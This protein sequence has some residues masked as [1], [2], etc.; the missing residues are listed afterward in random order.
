MGGGHTET[1]KYLD[2]TGV[3]YG[4][5]QVDGKIRVSSM[6]YLYDI[7]EGNVTGHSSWEKYAINDD[8]D[9][10]AEEDI[11]SVGGSYAWLAAETQ[12]AAVSSSVEDDPS[13]AD[14]SAGT[15]VWSVR[16]YYLDDDFV[17]RTTD[18]TLNGT[19]AV[20]LS[21][22]NVYRINRIRP[23]TMGTGNK[24]AGNID[25]K[26]PAPGTT[27][28]TR[29]ALGFTKGRQ[30][31][32]TVPTGKVLYI[33][34]MSGS[35]GGTSAPKYGKFILRSNYDNVSLARNAWFMAYPEHGAESGNFD[36]EFKCP[37]KFPA[38]SDLVV[39]CKTLDDNCYV[40]SSLRGWL[41][42]A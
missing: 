5:K 35:I 8:I 36:R 22:A 38:G 11:W 30:L 2:N 1:I 10:A 33:T 31:V 28:Y 32:Y 19:A 42:T 40:T 25:I 12:L 7:A 17:E 21:V 4:F 34:N 41:E 26:L 37:L 18:V 24:A 13:K 39:S 16:V 3:A 15:G 6:P 27:I 14:L 9:S 29:I 23:L 20:N